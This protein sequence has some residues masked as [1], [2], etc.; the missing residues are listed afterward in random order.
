M[1][2]GDSV[3]DRRG[4][5]LWLWGI[6]SFQLKTFAMYRRPGLPL[7]LVA[8]AIGWV[9]IPSAHPQIACVALKVAMSGFYTYLEL[10][11]CIP[12]CDWGLNKKGKSLWIGIDGFR[13]Y[14]SFEARV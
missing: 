1:K 3:E 6:K 2:V 5:H 14:G 11:Y 10:G 9:P 8:G 7:P 4:C 12:C 13:V